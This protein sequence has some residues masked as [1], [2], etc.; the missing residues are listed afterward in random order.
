MKQSMFNQSRK[1]A[2]IA[3]AVLALCGLTF[4]GGG[5]QFIRC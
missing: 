3:L 1:K 4:I 2:R 5:K